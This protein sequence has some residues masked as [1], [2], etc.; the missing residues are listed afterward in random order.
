MPMMFNGVGGSTLHFLAG[1][2]RYR[3][4]DFRRGTEHGLYGTID[5][6][7]AYEELEPYYAEGDAV[8]GIS[9]LVGDPSN[10]PRPERD[11]PAVAPGKLGLRAARAFNDLGWAWWPG[12]NAILTRARE[13]RLACNS[14]GSCIGCPR[15]SLGSADHTFWPGAIAAGAELRTNARVSRISLGA[16]GKANGAE[17]IDRRTGDEHRVDAKMVIVSANG[18]GTPRLLLLSAQEGHPDGLANGNGLV[19]RHLMHHIY[20]YTDLFFDEPTEGFKGAFGFALASQQFA[21]TDISRG[22]VGGF[23]LFAAR[24]S[25]PMTSA[26]GNNSGVPLPWGEDHHKAFATR[27]GRHMTVAVQGEDLARP[28]NRIT[29]DDEVK[30]SSGLAAPHVD[31]KLGE[32]DVRLGNWGLDRSEELA[33]ALGAREVN[34]IGVAP[35]PP[36]WHLLGTARI[37]NTPEDSTCNSVHQTWEVPNLFV[38]DGSSLPTSGSVNPTSTITAVALRC[39]DHIVAN[40]RQ[41]LDQ[42]RTP[43]NAEAA[44]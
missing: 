26:N 35:M 15:G 19:G 12:D 38:V 18:I 28:E 13:R 8:V 6:P 10:P 22:F 9:G 2:P 16:D 27:F 24:S 32:N 39:A 21:E 11:N 14:C 41:I 3:P 4:A 20:G 5:W 7:F 31:Y 43:G 40:H 33:K 25:G 29:L 1:W 44:G 30:D 17:Y 37:G 23:G 36:A 34:R 42:T